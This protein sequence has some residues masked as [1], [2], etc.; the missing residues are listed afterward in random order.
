LR[1]GWSAILRFAISRHFFCGNINLF[2][3]F[4]SVRKRKRAHADHGHR[5]VHAHLLLLECCS[6]SLAWINSVTTMET[7]VVSREEDGVTVELVWRGPAWLGEGPLWHPTEGALY[8]VRCFS[9]TSCALLRSRSRS[10]SFKMRLFSLLYLPRAGH[11]GATSPS[12]RT[13]G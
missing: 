5:C 10:Q 4:F 13:Y 12:C 11:S 6:H 9:C 8:Y 3:D 1:A 2:F 7:S